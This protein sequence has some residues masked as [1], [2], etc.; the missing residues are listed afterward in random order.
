MKGLFSP[1][2]DEI[3]SFGI[4]YNEMSENENVFDIPEDFEFDKYIYTPK[5]L[6]VFNPEGFTLIENNL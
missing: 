3:I 4:A 1:D 6:G 2:Q 5:V